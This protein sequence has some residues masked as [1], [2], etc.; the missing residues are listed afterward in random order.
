MNESKDTLEYHR[1]GSSLTNI[2]LFFS[3]FG[4]I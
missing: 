3:V 4:E 2:M 1:E